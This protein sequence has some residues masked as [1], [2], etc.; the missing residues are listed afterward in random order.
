[1]CVWERERERERTSSLGVS[2]MYSGRHWKSLPCDMWRMLCSRARARVCVCV[3][4]RRS[5]LG[6]SNKFLLETPRKLLLCSILFERGCVRVSE[7]VSEWVSEREKKR[8]SSLNVCN[9]HHG[10][11]GSLY[12]VLFKFC[13]VYACLCVC[14]FV[15]ERERKREW[16]ITPMIYMCIY[17][18]IYIYICIYPCALCCVSEL[19][20]A[21]VFLNPESKPTY[22]WDCV[23][24]W[25]SLMGTVALYRV[26]STGLR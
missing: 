25:L 17:I 24:W 20:R 26:C 18:H 7:R 14:V 11:R 2:N 1:M 5:F 12:S 23:R 8:R 22:V 21:D 4:E 10:S 15:C 3:C 9:G 19:Q 13:S 6:V 16:N